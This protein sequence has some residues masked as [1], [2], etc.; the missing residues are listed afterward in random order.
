MLEADCV[1]Q[2]IAQEAKG[3]G[4][5]L[6]TQ[7]AA[8]AWAPFPESSPYLPLYASCLD[9]QPMRLLPSP[10]P[11]LPSRLSPCR[12]PLS[13][14]PEGWFLEAGVQYELYTG[15][16]EERRMQAAVD[17]HNARGSGGKE[18][19][20][21]SAEQAQAALEGSGQ[22]GL[23]GQD[24]VHKG[25]RAPVKAE[26]GSA[27]ANGLGLHGLVKGDEQGQEHGKER[28]MQEQAGTANGVGDGKGEGECGAGGPLRPRPRPWGRNRG[29][30]LAAQA[31]S[32]FRPRGASGAGGVG[33]MCNGERGA[34]GE[35]AGSAVKRQ[36]LG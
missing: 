33:R 8:L 2:G 36:R 22:Q 3:A 35:G 4:A 16:E 21:D 24:L 19:A 1:V 25:I 17:K 13:S 15:E 9:P 5:A 14:L 27:A 7:A 29:R 20:K 10:L 11:Q 30:L 31:L 6:C 18:G 26:S 12:P 34:A 28:G 23:G 32:L